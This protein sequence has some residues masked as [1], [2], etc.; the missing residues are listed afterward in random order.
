[1][2]NVVIDGI[3]AMRDKQP[4]VRLLI[5][6]KPAAQLSMAQARKIAMDILQMSAR[7]EADA[8]IHRF[9]SQHDFPPGANAAIMLDFR[10]FRLALDTEPV[11]GFH[12]EPQGDNA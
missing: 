11:E 4:Y 8:I 7:T 6:D 3:V 2:P 5:D 1:M 9:F 12:S 10:E